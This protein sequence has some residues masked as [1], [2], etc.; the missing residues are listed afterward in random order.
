MINPEDLQPTQQLKIAVITVN[1]GSKPLSDADR[2]KL[3]DQCG[4][5]DIILLSVQEE[6][7]HESLAE[8]IVGAVDSGLHLCDSYWHDTNTGT[9]NK[10]T[11]RACP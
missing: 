5:A 11:T 4:D 10:V 9:K 3:I 7:R 6:L 8:D 1:A 2:K